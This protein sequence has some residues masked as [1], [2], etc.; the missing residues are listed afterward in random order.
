MLF[1]KELVILKNKFEGIKNLTK[2]PDAVLILDLKKDITCAKEARKKGIKVI[3]VVD[4]NTDPT[5]ADYIVPAN[6]DAISSIKY[7]LEKIQ[8]VI[9]GAK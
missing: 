5:L 8:E 7:L 6:D 2:L 4:T 9:Q 3:G 1:D